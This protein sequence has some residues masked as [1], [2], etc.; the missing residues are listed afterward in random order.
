MLEIT[1]KRLMK[2]GYAIVFNP[3]CDDEIDIQ[4]FKD[5]CGY[6]HRVRYDKYSLKNYNLDYIIRQGL[7]IAKKGVDRMVELNENKQY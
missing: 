1:I 7:N 6:T 3:V 4:V 5:G 2:K